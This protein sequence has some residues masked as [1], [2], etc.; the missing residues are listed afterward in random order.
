[1]KF[2]DKVLEVMG[3]G[4]TRRVRKNLLTSAKAKDQNPQFG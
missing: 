4:A 3:Q 1:M 2:S